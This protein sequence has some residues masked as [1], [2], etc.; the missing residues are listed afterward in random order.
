MN[1]NTNTALKLNSVLPA[2]YSEQRLPSVYWGEKFLTEAR[3]ESD[4]PAI[5]GRVKCIA[6]K[7]DEPT[8]NNTVYSRDLWETVLKSKEFNDRMK[9]K[10]V[11]GNLD[12]PEKP[13]QKAKDATHAAVKVW[14]EGN[15]VWAEFE[16]F[17]TPDGRILFTLLRAG[18]ILGVS[19]RSTGTDEEK[20]G[21]IYL[22]PSTFKLIGW[23]FVVDES[24]F[25][26]M[27][28]EF[29]EEKKEEIVKVI[30]EEKGKAKNK[31][32]VD[33]IEASEK[34]IEEDKKILDTVKSYDETISEYRVAQVKS[35]EET[36]ALQEEKVHLEE[37]ITSMEKE[38]IQLE[39]KIR[40]RDG[41]IVLK[42][43]GAIKYREEIKS[44]G[45]K[46]GL[47]EEKLTEKE[48]IIEEQ[49]GVIKELTSRKS[50]SIQIE[51]KEF[52]EDKKEES[53]LERALK[54]THSV[55]K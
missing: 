46:I 18:V 19:S 33:M 45:S 32:I 4:N 8:F 7:A 10:L 21:K 38:K 39:E 55:K 36:R 50:I 5:L 34:K 6:S 25:G 41:V 15:E 28:K 53:A 1:Y 17:D 47:F 51:K 9:R 48:K 49:K 22:I 24:A 31:Y 54:K 2:L 52:M 27:F 30:N 42:E 12:H 29:A 43:E 40:E 44:L 16:I 23:D 3:T 26:A 14:I 37:K 11:M 20:G 35:Y 13:K